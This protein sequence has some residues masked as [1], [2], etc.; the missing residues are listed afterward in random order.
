MQ[1]EDGG[2]SG[3][4]LY[5]TGRLNALDNLE[6]VEVFL[7]SGRVNKWKWVS[8]AMFHALYGYLLE[9]LGGTFAKFYL[10]EDEEQRTAVRL[11]IEEEMAIDAIVTEINRT[12]TAR[13]PDSRLVTKRMVERWVAAPKVIGIDEAL[14]RMTGKRGKKGAPSRPAMVLQL[15][16]TSQQRKDIDWLIKEIRNNFEHFMPKHWYIQLRG[17]PSILL[18]MLDSIRF[19]ALE[20]H[21]VLLD[22]NEQEHIA[23][24]CSRIRLML[25]AR[26]IVVETAALKASTV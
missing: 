21:G 5:T 3:P 8:L 16:L 18:D 4:I 13:D 26:R 24:L 25:E 15:K 19:I 1:I 9:A 12:R 7:V 11:L 6:M 14:D 22:P 2:A 10:A 23:S 20:S 17:L